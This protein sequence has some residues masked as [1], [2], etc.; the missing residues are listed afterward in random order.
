MVGIFGFAQSL[1]VLRMS[2]ITCNGF[3]LRNTG[4]QALEK[5]VTAKE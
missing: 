5:S 1:K 4:I 3:M 2:Y